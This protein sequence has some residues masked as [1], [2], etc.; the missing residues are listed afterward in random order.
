MKATLHLQNK[1]AE[2]QF[3]GILAQWLQPQFNS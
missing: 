1:K 3:Q 2:N